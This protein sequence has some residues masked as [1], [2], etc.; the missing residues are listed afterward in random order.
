MY[1]IK[2]LIEYYFTLFGPIN[3]NIT[4]KNQSLYTFIFFTTPLNLP[5]NY[6]VTQNKINN[7]SLFTYSNTH[8]IIKYILI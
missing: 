3:L 6:T 5:V 4:L 8:M 7:L 2:N 1:P